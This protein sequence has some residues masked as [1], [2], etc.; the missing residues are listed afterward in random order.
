MSRNKC[1]Q[2]KVR[3]HSQF[4][5]GFGSGE[6]NC[7]QSLS[8]ARI[9]A[10]GLDAG[11]CHASTRKGHAEHDW[12]PVD[13]GGGNSDKADGQ[14]EQLLCCPEGERGGG[15]PASSKP[16]FTCFGQAS[17]QGSG[18]RGAPAWQLSFSP[19]ERQTAPP[20][21]QL[22]CPCTSAGVRSVIEALATCRCRCFRPATHFWQ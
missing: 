21:L 3:Q 22:V 10:A 11:R 2:G 9:R 5:R 14:D 19:R 17:E 16:F 13:V 12:T 1:G 18:A 6:A 7:C 15:W 4:E 20:G 8:V